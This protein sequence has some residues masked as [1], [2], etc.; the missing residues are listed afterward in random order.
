MSDAMPEQN[1]SVKD[2]Q[3]ELLELMVRFHRMCMDAGVQYSLHGGT[4]LG[5][6]REHGFIPWDDDADVSMLRSEY[7][8][9]EAT[10]RNVSL[11]ESMRFDDTDRIIHLIMER[12]GKPLVWLDIFIYD[13][14]SEHKICSK[15]KIAIITFFIMFTKP[16]ENMCFV[17]ARGTCRGWK[18]WVYDTI[19]KFGSLFS[20]TSRINWMKRFCKN[21]LIGHKIMIHRGLDQ[22]A[23]IGLILPKETMQS[24]RIVPFESTE[25]MISSHYH[26]ILVSSYGE[27][28]MTPKYVKPNEANVHTLARQLFKK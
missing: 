4:L 10:L 22:Y 9:I 27:D 15:L 8:K 18:Y 7:E 24:F 3:E 25:L 2:I 14:I 21:C 12:Q 1:F 5:A 28:Y 6:I 16:Q 11:D 17:K 19:S 23:A 20:H 26:E 13:Y